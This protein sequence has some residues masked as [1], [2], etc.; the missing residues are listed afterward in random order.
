VNGTITQEDETLHTTQDHPEPS[1]TPHTITQ[2]E[3]NKVRQSTEKAEKHNKRARKTSKS[4]KA[5]KSSTVTKARTAKRSFSTLETTRPLQTESSSS[6]PK[7]KTC[8]EWGSPHFIGW[9][10][11]PIPFP[12]DESWTQSRERRERLAREE[13]NAQG[14]SPPPKLAQDKD[15]FS[16]FEEKKTDDDKDKSLALTTTPLISPPP[17]ALATEHPTPRRVPCCPFNLGLTVDGIIKTKQGQHIRVNDKVTQK[18]SPA[19]PITPPRQQDHEIEK[20]APSKPTYT[21]HLLQYNLHN[22]NMRYKRLTQ[23]RAKLMRAIRKT[24][25]QMGQLDD[26]H[27]AKTRPPSRTT[28]QTIKRKLNFF[29]PGTADHLAN[30]A[31]PWMLKPVDQS[32]F[33]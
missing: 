12:E 15:I 17:L 7:P 31:V 5:E 33:R 13:K 26:P 11:N 8:H 6:P 22:L 1:P 32:T 25:R 30:A 19:Q 4:H 23:R 2:D 21:S 16:E 28:Q 10:W 3:S 14:S 27:I 20:D 18:E 29:I 9:G 24:H